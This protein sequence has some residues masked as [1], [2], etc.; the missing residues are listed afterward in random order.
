MRGDR[1][2]GATCSLRPATQK[3]LIAFIAE[4]A[5]TALANSMIVSN[6]ADS[7]GVAG[8]FRTERGPSCENILLIVSWFTPKGI[9]VTRKVAISTT[10]EVLLHCGQCGQPMARQGEVDQNTNEAPN[11][12]RMAGLR[13][14]RRRFTQ[15]CMLSAQCRTDIVPQD[16][17]SV[18]DGGSTA[19]TDGLHL[20]RP[21]MIG[22]PMAASEAVFDGGCVR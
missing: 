6:G 8:R 12:G 10:R 3:P 2:T 15:D 13:R 14:Q 18:L 19:C 22:A 20:L 17:E 9:R 5:A 7:C 11:A 4:S 1:C 16:G 21:S